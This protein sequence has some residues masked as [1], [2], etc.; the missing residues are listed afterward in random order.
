MTTADLMAEFKQLPKEVRDYWFTQAVKIKYHRATVEWALRG[1]QEFLRY[2]E[3]FRPGTAFILGTGPSIERVRKDEWIR[4]REYFT[5]GVNKTAHWLQTTRDEFEIPAL[6]F[7]SD[8]I[9]HKKS[10]AQFAS[11]FRQAK[12]KRLVNV[13]ADDI[14]HDWACHVFTGL[15]SWDLELGPFFQPN[16]GGYSKWAR[17]I[18]AAAHLAAMTGHFKMIVLI[19]ADHGPDYFPEEPEQASAGYAALAELFREHGIELVNSSLETHV[20]TLPYVRLSAIL[21]IEKEG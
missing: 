15:P 20:T 18:A 4:L 8:Q 3:T 16:A 5:I 7:M 21:Q 12:G 6:C 1:S 19:G 17:S 9:R 2:V 13:S 11:S 10:Q 14:P